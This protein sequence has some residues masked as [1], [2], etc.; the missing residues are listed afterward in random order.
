MM[1]L[2]MGHLISSNFPFGTNGKLVVLGVPV[3][4]HFR[5]YVFV[6]VE[7]NYFP[8][9]HISK[10]TLSRALQNIGTVSYRS[11]LFFRGK[12]SIVS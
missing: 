4:K 5:V 9:I 7:E 10:Y 2:N 8:V 1:C 3:L 6:Q 12:S 11:S